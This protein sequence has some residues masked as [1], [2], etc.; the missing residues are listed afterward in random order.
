[1]KGN[2]IMI[3]TKTLIL[4][5]LIV[6]L[7]SF[8][9]LLS[10]NIM[11]N[12]FLFC[13]NSNVSPLEITRSSEGFTVDNQDLNAYIQRNNIINTKFFRYF[14]LKIKIT[15][16]THTSNPSSKVKFNI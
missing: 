16:F 8:N 4:R 7:G 13:L 10:N 2:T 6:A 14:H 1:M 9:F 12:T 3:N 15:I 11:E 5:F